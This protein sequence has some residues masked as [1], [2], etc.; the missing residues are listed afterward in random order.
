[1]GAIRIDGC[2]LR[3]FKQRALPAQISWCSKTACCSA[4]ACTTTSR[5]DR[6]YD[7]P[8][9]VAVTLSGGERQR[10]AL[11]R[12]LLNHAPILILHEATLALHAESEVELGVI[13]RA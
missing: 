5:L 10:I 4:T 3:E 7:T 11:A 12:A 1:V 6:G 13:P 2:D 9:N 8:A